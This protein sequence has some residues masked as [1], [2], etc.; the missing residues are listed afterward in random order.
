MG[1]FGDLW[2]DITGVT[3]SNTAAAA[4]QTGIANAQAQLDPYTS[5]GADAQQAQLAM[6]GALG[7]E[8]QQ[9]AISGIQSSPMF[10]GLV[11]QGED[12]ILQNAAAT[13]GL[14]GGNTQGML[15]QFAPQ[16]LN[17]MIQQRFQNLGSLSNR[18]LAASQQTAGLAVDS[19]N[20]AASNALGNY[21]LQR[22]FVTDIAGAG[23]S[24]LGLP[25]AAGIGKGIM[26]GL[27][28]LF[29]GGGGSLKPA[30]F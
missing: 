29:G 9:Q 1:F 20:V 11:A 12:S 26:G 27:N 24:L 13:G 5:G 8:A 3:A 28:S 15:A 22:G 23:L 25:G 19:G 30:K 4:Q 10:Q 14:R 21:N 7:P 17:Q 16:M 2:N 18:G 6:T